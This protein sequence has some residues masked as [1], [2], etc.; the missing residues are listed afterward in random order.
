DD[1]SGIGRDELGLAFDRYATSKLSGID[2]LQSIAT[3]GFRG[4]ALPSLAAVARVEIVTCATGETAGEALTVGEGR[5][6]ESGQRARSQGTTVTVRGLFRT[7]PARLKFLKSTSTENSHIA[8]IVSRYALAFPEVSFSLTID[9]RQV[10]TTPGGGRL[11]DG[12]V[13]V[14]GAEIAAKM[15]TLGDGAES[16]SGGAAV[17]GMVS[18]PELTRANRDYLNFF[19]NRRAIGS[20][21]LTWAVEQAYHGMLMTGRHPLA[22]ID[23]TL[24]PSE[25]D[26]NIHPTKAEVKFRNERAVFAA[27]Q[28]TIRSRLTDLPP[29]TGWQ[30]RPSSIPAI[31]ERGAGYSPGPPRA[32][33]GPVAPLWPSPPPTE[34]LATPP[35]APLVSLP[36]LRVVGQVAASY[37]VAEGPDGVYLVDQHAAH[38]RILFEQIK[39]QR[40]ERGIEVQGL[41]EPASLEVTPAQDEVLKADYP[42]LAEFGFTIEPFGERSYLVRAIPA[43]LGSE[44]WRETLWEL[45]DNTDGGPAADWTER[46]AVTLA[47]HGAVRAGKLLS[48]DEM[49]QLIR[50]LE[51]TALARTCPHGRPTVLHISSGQLEREFRRRP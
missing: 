25:I 39:R 41:L 22:I 8:R 29:T 37:I 48:D 12:V 44:D 18:P 23:I 13:A 24:P 21:L 28:K 26:V 5:V 4:E 1:G 14:Y 7:V 33:S 6:L 16:G 36:A 40:A 9:G 17:A 30:P 20:R 31:G 15:L 42:R 46:T 19:V 51:E 11:I 38:E 49:R 45:M 2:D 34:T 3:L 27:V 47:C 35:Q 32:S 10:V 43:V 50:E